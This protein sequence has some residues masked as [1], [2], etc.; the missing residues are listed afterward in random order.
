MLR[1]NEVKLPLDHPEA[2]LHSAILARQRSAIVLI[3]SVD[4]DLVDE[5][6]VLAAMKHD[7]HVLPSPDTSYKFVAGGAQL[8]GHDESER[9]VVIGTGPCGLFAALI[10][11]QMGPRP[12]PATSLS[13]AASSSRAMTWAS[14]RSSSAPARAA[15][16][17]RWCWRRWACVH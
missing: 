13:P 1:I 7:I 6:G 17:W 16:S 10:L 5:A 8:Q 11:A 15:C 4:V 9:P 3:Y 2:A 12:T 14:A